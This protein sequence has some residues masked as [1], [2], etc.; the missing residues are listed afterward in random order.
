MISPKQQQAFVEHTL[1]EWSKVVD[2]ELTKAIRKRER[3]IPT[4]TAEALRQDIEMELS[5]ML[6][7]YNLS[8]PDSG[9]HVDMKRLD[10][11]SRPITEDKNFILEW[12]KK[13]GLSKFRKGVPGYKPGSK[14]G[15]SEDKQLERIAS[16]IIASY[17]SDKTSRRR[18]GA[19]YNRTIYKLLDE[20]TTMLVKGQA[21][22][23]ADGVRKDLSMTLGGKA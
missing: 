3:N 1:R 4:G 16:A 13:R 19:W 6:A 21:E 8:F 10:Y 11:K 12:A 20:L 23:F 14:P 22:F 5:Q 2:V 7:N 18:R 17:D 9:R 15:I